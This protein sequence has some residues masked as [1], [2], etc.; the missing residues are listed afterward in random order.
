MSRMAS[1]ALIGAG[2]L[3]VSAC[4]LGAPQLRDPDRGLAA[5]DLRRCV[6]SLAQD[7]A[8]FVEPIRYSGSAD[9]ARLALVRIIAAMAGGEVVTQSPDYVHARFTSPRMKYVDDLELMFPPDARLVHLRAASRLGY[10]DFNVNRERIE[11]LRARFEAL[12]P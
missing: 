1:A 4:G 6:S 12:Q 8:H 5:C 3:A 9:A 11:E 7:D 2:C 10:Y